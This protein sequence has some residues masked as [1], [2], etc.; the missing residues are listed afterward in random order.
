MK[1]LLLMR[2]AKSSWSDPARDDHDRPLNKRGERDAPVVARLIADGGWVPDLIVSSSACRARQTA[3]V[4][5]ES[6]AWSADVWLTRRLYLA[7]PREYLAL[8]A[9]VPDAAS[10]VLMIGHNPGLEQ[11]ASELSGVEWTL[12]TAALVV[13][14]LDVERWEDVGLDTRAQIVGNHAPRP[15]D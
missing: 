1:T 3:L 9:Q 13:F 15:V 8:L 7:E 5:A 10:R 14:S 4:I 2:H 11:L 6:S 12:P